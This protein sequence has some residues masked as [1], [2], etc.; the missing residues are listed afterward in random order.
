MFEHL[1]VLLGV[2]VLPVLRH[3]HGRGLVFTSLH[4]SLRVTSSD[5]VFGKTAYIQQENTKT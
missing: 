2:Y 3:H 4:H 5:I 1:S